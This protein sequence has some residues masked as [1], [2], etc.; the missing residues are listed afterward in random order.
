MIFV[1]VLMG[2]AREGGL[3][4]RSMINVQK[5]TWDSNREIESEFKLYIIST[6]IQIVP[7]QIPKSS[8]QNA[9]MTLIL[10]I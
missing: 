10:K 2:K 7:V 5:K 4:S 3:C 8:N 9:P 1:E 6:Y